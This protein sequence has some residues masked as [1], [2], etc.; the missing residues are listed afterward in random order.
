M[1]SE[2]KTLYGFLVGLLV[3]F[4][5]RS[6]YGCWILEPTNDEGLWLWNARSDH[7]NLPA[8]G[9]FHSGLSPYYYAIA[10]GVFFF[11]DPGIFPLRLT[12]VFC[13]VGVVCAV[14]YS[15]CFVRHAWAALFFLLFLLTDPYLFRAASSA[16]VEPQLLAFTGLLYLASNRSTSVRTKSMGCLAGAC[17]A[18]KLTSLPNIAGLALWVLLHKPAK[19]RSVFFAWVI[20]LPALAYFFMERHLS[21]E[22]FYGVWASHLQRV[23]HPNRFYLQSYFSLSTQSIR[24]LF[25]LSTIT[26]YVTARVVFMVRKKSLH[27]GFPF[28]ASLFC[29]GN[30]FLSAPI[31]PARYMAPSVF[32]VFI[33]GALLC[34]RHVTRRKALLIFASV[35]CLLSNGICFPAFFLHQKNRGGW[36]LAGEVQ[37]AVAKGKA[38][39][40]PPW[41]AVGVRAP[42]QPSS[43][44]SVSTPCQ[45][46]PPDFYI[47]QSRAAELSSCDRKYLS[48]LGRHG[49]L[50][51]QK[52][53]YQIYRR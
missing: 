10:R 27:L 17:L 8:L 30:I 25:Y 12:N 18:T 16:M 40:A 5:I 21:W 13:L 53:F 4:A 45:P 29:A 33:D 14:A 35:V 20:L 15:F 32:L 49:F 26:G 9:I 44:Y 7:W 48:Y 43:A 42:I 41:V 22:K 11:T 3:L 47:F 1:R 28:L 46:V 39:S 37:D 19:Q 38:V 36:E 50:P 51:I 34:G 52:G 31:V 6:L 2:N 24:E 23:Q